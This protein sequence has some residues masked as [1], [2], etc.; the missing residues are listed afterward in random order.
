[1]DTNNMLSL[2]ES[3]MP[4]SSD[5]VAHQIAADF[6]RRRIEKNITRRQIADKSG[7]PAASIARFEQKGLISLKNLIELA[8]ALGYISELR[9][10]FSTPKYDTMDELLRIRKNANKK[11]ASGK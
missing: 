9:T 2:L 10:V 6:K 7:V 8:T 1:M 3:L 4:P 5:E 11:K